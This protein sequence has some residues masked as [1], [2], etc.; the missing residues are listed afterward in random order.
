MAGCT[1]HAAAQKLY[2]FGRWQSLLNTFLCTFYEHIY[3]ETY[4][5]NVFEKKEEQ[6]DMGIDEYNTN[7]LKFEKTYSI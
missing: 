4:I 5:F 1:K 6:I 7:S 2:S 3:D